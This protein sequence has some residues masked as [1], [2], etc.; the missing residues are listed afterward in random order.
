[1]GDLRFGIQQGCWLGF[2]FLGGY[3]TLS[4]S[5]QGFEGCYCCMGLWL[6]QQVGCSGL[7]LVDGSEYDS[8]GDQEGQSSQVIQEGTGFRFLNALS[9]V[10]VYSVLIIDFHYFLHVTIICEYPTIQYYLPI[11]SPRITHFIQDINSCTMGAA[12]TGDRYFLC[13]T[14]H[15]HRRASICFCP[16]Q[17]GSIETMTWHNF[18]HLKIV[19]VRLCGMAKSPTIITKIRKS[20]ILNVRVYLIFFRVLPPKSRI[21]WVL[22]IHSHV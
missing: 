2:L 7:S 16:C 10:L 11:F 22:C 4:G 19:S 13:S 17:P 5:A 9:H 3:G 21:Q 1:M 18:R 12:F 14:I 20:F 6:S 8:K 15:S